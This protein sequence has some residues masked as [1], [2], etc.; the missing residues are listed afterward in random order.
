M[1]RGV[2][3]STPVMRSTFIAARSAG[4]TRP[5]WMRVFCRNQKTAKPAGYPSN[6]YVPRCQGIRFDEVA[7]RFHQF[8]HQGGENLVGVNRVFNLNL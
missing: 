3:R 8:T 7:P 4:S 2:W 1:R 5:V 6:V